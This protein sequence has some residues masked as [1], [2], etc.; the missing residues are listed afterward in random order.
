M[1]INNSVL[2]NSSELINESELIANEPELLLGTKELINELEKTFGKIIKPFIYK[3]NEHNTTDIRITFDKE[4]KFEQEFANAI[5]CSDLNKIFSKY[6]V[7]FWIHNENSNAANIS[8]TIESKYPLVKKSCFDKKDYVCY[9]S[10]YSS[11]WIPKLIN[12]RVVKT[13]MLP[14]ITSNEKK[15][16]LLKIRDDSL[17]MIGCTVKVDKFFQYSKKHLKNQLRVKNLK[18]NFLTIKTVTQK[19]EYSVL[20]HTIQT[21]LYHL[22]IEIDIDELEDEMSAQIKKSTDQVILQKGIILIEINDYELPV[23]QYPVPKNITKVLSGYKQQNFDN[24]QQNFDNK[25]QKFNDNKQQK[26][27]G[28][29]QQKFNDYGQQKFNGYKRLNKK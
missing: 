10:N 12:N 20:D 19:V 13:V 9:L 16:V 4:Y 11:T 21:K 25:R 2:N 5:E 24:K 6:L 8:K 23:L 26:F 28:Y 3:K 27:N 29:K 14:I 17:V 7:V 1:E 18:N 15:Y 22:C